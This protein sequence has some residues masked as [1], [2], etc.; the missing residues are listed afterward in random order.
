MAKL[1][2]S[3]SPQTLVVVDGV[4]SVAGEEIRMD[5][6]GIDVVMTASQKALGAAPGLSLVVASEHAMRV[7]HSRQSPVTSF[8]CSWKRWLP[9]MLSY[10]ARKASYFATPAVQLI[11]GLHTSLKMILALG[12]ETVLERHRAVSNLVKNRIQSWGLD[13]VPVSRD[14]A[15][16]TLTAAYLP[17][18]VSGADLVAKVASKGV[19]IAGGLHPTIRAKYFRVGHMGISATDEAQTFVLQTLDAIQASLEECGYSCKRE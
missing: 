1:I 7:F 13:I 12:M 18:G 9:I 19:L 2:K 6:W 10:E 4:C 17:T 15:A 16:H 14:A 8:Y 5:A 11:M 3:V